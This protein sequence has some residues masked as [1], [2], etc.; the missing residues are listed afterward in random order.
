MMN[1]TSQQFRRNLIL[2]N[3]DRKHVILVR[4][5]DI[6]TDSLKRVLKSFALGKNSY[7][8]KIDVCG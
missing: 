5:V 6:S 2:G 8:G 3:Q 4:E 1:P 7:V